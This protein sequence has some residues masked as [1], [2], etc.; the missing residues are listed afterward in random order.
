ME[1]SERTVSRRQVLLTL[2]GAGLAGGYLLR[3]AG[4]ALEGASSAEPE[5]GWPLV[6][7]AFLRPREKYWLGW[8]G[9][10]WDVDGFTKKS[11]ESVEKFGKELKVRVAFE[12]EPLY[13][14]P[15]VD[16]FLEKVKTEKPHGVLLFP[17]HMDRWGA[18][19]KLSKSG[20]PTIVFAGLGVA[21]T[22]HIA[23]ISR[24]PQIYLAS[25]ADFELKPVRFGLKMVR[26][27]HDIRQSKVVVI[28]G[29]ETKE[30]TLEPLGLKLR[31]VPRKTF[32]ET[33]KGIEVT[34]EV[35][36][37]VA[38]YKRTA[39]K[40]VEPTEADL[41]NAARNY[42][43]ALKIMK[44]EG[45]NGITMD[46]LGLVSDRQ[47]P[48]PPCLAWSKLLDVGIPGVCEADINGVMSHTL[49][50]RLLDKG[51]FMQDP[52]PD[53]VS[54]TFIGAHCVSPTR[55]NGYDQPSEPFAL[56]THAESN[57]GVSVQVF[58]KPG[59]D[60]TIMQFVGP[61][62][63]ILGKGKVLKNLDTPPAGGCRTS[64]ELAIDAPADTRD[65]KGFH[66]LFIYGDHMRDFQAYGQ[67]YGIATEHI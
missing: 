8:P 4:S 49:C 44:D 25:S 10:S 28:A 60:V 27:A 42:F 67:M 40:I 12:E 52:V 63:M 61:S 53:T 36:A 64:V 18:V 33:L 31:Y 37:V 38:E 66:Q 17:L 13:D 51:G 30:T 20:V 24:R 21:F 32:P 57:L 62:R 34:P 14:A 47:I 6:R 26:T 45:C 35:M 9:T 19:D 16:K 11:R 2:A 7:A 43:T 58:W 15:A 5:S 41:V 54:N 23:E 1:S 65:T 50:C 59:Q 55:L 3:A 29:G 22:G 46:C 48:C 56:R 39:R